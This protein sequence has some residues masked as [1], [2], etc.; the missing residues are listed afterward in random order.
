QTALSLVIGSHLFQATRGFLEVAKTKH[1][2]GLGEES[3]RACMLD[4]GRLRASQIAKGPVA[5]PGILQSNA[6]W[7]HAAEFAAGVLDVALVV[8]RRGRDG[9]GIAYVP[10]S[11]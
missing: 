3:A 4:H 10:S 9:M 8:P 1:A 2:G 5:D 11:F 7:L 6:G